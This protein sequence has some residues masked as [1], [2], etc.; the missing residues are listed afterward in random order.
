MPYQSASGD[1]T[2]SNGVLETRQLKIR[3]Q[4]MDVF[5]NGEVDFPQQTIDARLKLE[6]MSSMK[7]SLHA[8]PLVKRVVSLDTG[9]LQVP[10]RLRGRSII[11]KSTKRW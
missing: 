5:A 4:N 2:F 8:I 9:F 1:A 11:R 3:T 6:F 7:D 10:L